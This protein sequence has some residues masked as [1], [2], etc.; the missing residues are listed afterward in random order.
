MD[1]EISLKQMIKDAIFID[2]TF[3]LLQACFYFIDDI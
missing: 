3:H 1:D 2:K